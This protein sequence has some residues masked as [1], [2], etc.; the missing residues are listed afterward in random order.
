MSLVESEYILCRAIGGEKAR[1]KVEKLIASQAVEIVGD[2]SLIHQVAR[3]KRERSI[4]LGD[5]YSIALAENLK[6]SA[7]FARVEDDLRREMRRKQF[8][9]KLVF[10]EDRTP[11][12]S[13][14]INPK[15]SI[16][17]IALGRRKPVSLRL[18]GDALR[19]ARKASEEVDKAVYDE[20]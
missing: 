8:P 3:I 13:N 9:V 1:E 4:A 17:D 11:P 14:S 10:L 7:V 6:G 2:E 20:E 15:D 16:F 12:E 5:S 19:R 18:K